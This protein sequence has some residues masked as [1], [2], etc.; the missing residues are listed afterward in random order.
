MLPTDRYL[1]KVAI[2]VA[3]IILQEKMLKHNFEGLKLKFDAPKLPKIPG[4]RSLLSYNP[5]YADL[6]RISRR[7]KEL[8]RSLEGFVKAFHGPIDA[9]QAFTSF[10]ETSKLFW[11]LEKSL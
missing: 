9:F 2:P 10:R 11:W 7:L 6:N 4:T 5:Y 3:T 8:I 1:L